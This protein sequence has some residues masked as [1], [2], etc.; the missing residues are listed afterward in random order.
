MLYYIRLCL[1]YILTVV[2]LPFDEE[3]SHVGEAHIA[4]SS[5]QPL[6]I[7]GSLKKLIIIFS[8]QTARYQDLSATAT[9]KWYCQ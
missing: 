4:R 1:V 2:T 7:A 3:S 9:M 6:G 8:Q 5:E